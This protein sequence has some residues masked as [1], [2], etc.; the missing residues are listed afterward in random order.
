MQGDT[1]AASGY[2]NA[3]VSLVD[4]DIAEADIDA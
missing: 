2:A 3:A 4:D 1:A